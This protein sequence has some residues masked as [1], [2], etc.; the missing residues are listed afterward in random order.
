MKK[1]IC[2]IFT[3]L[4]LIAAIA[5]NA[6]GCAARVHATDLME[7]Y[8]ANSVE[9][10]EDLSEGSLEITDFAVRLFQASNE[11]GNTLISPLSVLCA[12]AMTLNGAEGETREEMEATLGMSTEELNNYI[13]SY[14]NALPQG[15]KYKLSLA[16]SIWFTEDESFDVNEQFL[17]TNKDYYDADVYAAPFNDRTLKDI[18]SWVKNETDEMIP[19]VLDEIPA[20]AVMYLINALAFEAEWSKIYEKHEVRNGVFTRED[21][22]EENVE[23][24]YSREGSYIESDNAKGFIKSYKGGK[25]A[26][27]ALLPNEGVSLSDYIAALDGEKISD[28][29]SSPE[30]VTVNAA[31]PKFEN[32]IDIAMSDVLREMGIEQAFDVDEADF[33]GLGTSTEGNIYI[34]NVIHKTFISVAEK[35]TRAGAVT[36]IEVG[37]DTSA[38]A[39]TEI[40]EVYLNRP[41]VYMLIDTETNIPFFIG[42]QMSIN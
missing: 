26:F 10:V 17:Q 2:L 30:Y 34:S 8:V 21:G 11:G 42:S 40:K 38:G 16:N 27:V 19:K 41:F 39:P 36:A 37:G 5:T 29:I 28:L 3:S 14:I 24:M 20:D 33:G 12:L 25:Y 23:F 1:R 4:L 9:G 18:N 31:I 35:G 7:G 32:E 6:I 15:E 22:N 13:Y